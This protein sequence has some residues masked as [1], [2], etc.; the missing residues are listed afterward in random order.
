MKTL[1]A[2]FVVLS[3]SIAVMSICS[4]LSTSLSADIIDVD[5]TAVDPRFAADFEA[6]EAFWESRIQN[7]ST[8]LPRAVLFQ[9]SS[10]RIIAS[11]AIIDGPGDTLAQ[12][13]P[14]RIVTFET[15][16]IFLSR[17]IAVATLSSLELDIEDLPLLEAQGILRDTIIHEMGHALGFGSLWAQNNL[18]SPLGGVG[19][20]QY[21]GGTYA[22]QEYRKEIRNPVANFVPLEQSGGDGTALSH[23]IDAPPFFNQVATRG[24][25]ELMTGFAD[26]LDPDTGTVIFPPNFVSQTTWGAMADLGYEVEGI[27]DNAVDPVRGT[28]SFPTTIGYNPGVNNAAN[29]T[30][31]G[32]VQVSSVKIRAVTRLAN[33]GSGKKL[34]TVIT[35]DANDPYRLRHQRWTK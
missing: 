21:T 12:A 11:T 34:E 33:N 26:D 9:L 4:L 28:G 10:L 32:G 19:L 20:T 35:T 30:L 1:F 23:W 13:G 25:K 15:N 16:N 6:A 29:L 5:R 22:I 31:S 7:Y 27:N 2:R 3:A 14:D 17:R 8:E 18:V 24:T